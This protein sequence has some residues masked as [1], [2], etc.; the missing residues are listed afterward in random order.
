MMFSL[1]LLWKQSK[2]RIRATVIS[3]NC[4]GNFDLFIYKRNKNKN[5]KSER[6]K[7]IETI[8]RK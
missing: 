7:L 1:Y 4:T 3:I 8:L 5:D 2:K 6:I